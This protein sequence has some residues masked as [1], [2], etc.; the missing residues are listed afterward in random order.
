VIELDARRGRA[1]LGGWHPALAESQRIYGQV[2]SAAAAAR[3]RHFESVFAH[4]VSIEEIAA[5]T[6]LDACEVR[7]VLYGR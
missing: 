1:R 2:T 6:G 3:R 7:A 4:G 5:A